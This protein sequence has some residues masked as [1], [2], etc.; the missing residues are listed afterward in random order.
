MRRKSHDHNFLA[1]HNSFMFKK[2]DLITLVMFKK[3][4]LITLVM[5]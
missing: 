3:Y 2:Y 1:L 5:L 4:D